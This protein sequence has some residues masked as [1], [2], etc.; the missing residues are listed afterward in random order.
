MIFVV[1]VWD[2]RFSTLRDAFLGRVI[3]ITPG[4]IYFDQ[5]LTVSVSVVI[6][7]AGIL[8][9]TASAHRI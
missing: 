5:M 4:S 7:T 2:C 1:P 8:I 9:S 3:A 6:S